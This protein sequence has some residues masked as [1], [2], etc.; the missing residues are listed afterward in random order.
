M[1]ATHQAL[2]YLSPISWS[3]IPHDNLA[4]HLKPIFDA[5]ELLVNTIPPPPGGVPFQDAQPYFTTPN[6]AKSAKEIHTSEAR[7]APP[8]AEHAELQKHWGK[9]MKFNKKDNPLDVAVFKMAG[10]DRHGSWFARHQVVE[11]ISFTKFKQALMREFPETLLVQGEP[12]AGAK[13]GLS[14]ERRVERVDVDGV[15]RMEVYQ[16]SAQMPSPVS[17][18]DFLTLLLTTEDGLSNKSSA[19]AA[20]GGRHVPRSYMIVSRPLQHE[21]APQRTAFVRGQY[22]S[23]ELIREI[24]LHVTKASADQNEG[25]SEEIDPELNPVQWLMITRSDPGGGLPRFLVD[26]GTPPAM[27]ADVTKFL[28]W[29]CAY[30]EVPEQ[31]SDLK[32]QQEANRA[33]DG[34]DVTPA[35]ESSTNMEQPTGKGQPPRESLDDTTEQR[36]R[37]ATAPAVIEPSYDPNAPADGGILSNLT[38]TVEAALNT[39]APASVA[40]YVNKQLGTTNGEDADSSDSSDT[41]SMDSFLSAAEMKRMSTAPESMPRASTENISVASAA[42]STDVSKTDRKNMN[43]HEK[44]ILK[45]NR[46]R[47]KLEQKLARKRQTEEEKLKASQEKDSTDS[48]K[49]REKMEKELQKTEERHQKEVE[50]LERKKERE[51]R[52]AQEKRDK[53]EDRDRVTMVARERDEARRQVDLWRKENELLREQVESLQRENTA[54][55]TRLGKLGAADSLNEFKSRSRA[56]TK[57]GESVMSGP[58]LEE[59]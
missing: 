19:E 13:R 41:S 31:D 12:G 16:L 34:A 43:Q 40:E 10:N 26:R 30:E 23:V 46:Q 9:P 22:E 6:T 11:G 20:S 36:R 58:S 29:A 2:T 7:P 55:T 4:E 25:S 53:K 27:L 1:A 21:D 52:K 59:K 24:P 42:S 14:A 38:H 18:R 49:A 17:P 44:E 33:F 51:L 5:A 56:G 32:E 57:S 3:D 45:I 37:A 48:A 54:L 28:N 50:K 35:V 39:Y 15:G 8:D 47:E